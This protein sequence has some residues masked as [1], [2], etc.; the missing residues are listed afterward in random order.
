MAERCPR[1]ERADTVL[2]LDYPIRLS[3]T[4]LFKRIWK[5]RG[6]TRPDMADDWP[7]RFDPGFLFYLLQWNSG[8][9]LR[10]EAALKGHEAKVTD[11]GDPIQ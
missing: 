2:Y 4:R 6:Q 11:F 9:R 1:L 10:L 3:V 7:E 5:Y 8:P